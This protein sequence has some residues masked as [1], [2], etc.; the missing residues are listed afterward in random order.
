MH[1]CMP[2][3]WRSTSLTIACLSSRIIGRESGEQKGAAAS[4]LELVKQS[5]PPARVSIQPQ[6]PQTSSSTDFL[7]MGS[8]RK[9]FKSISDKEKDE[10]ADMAQLHS[11]LKQYDKWQVEHIAKFLREEGDKDDDQSDYYTSIL[12][13]SSKLSPSTFIFKSFLPYSHLTL[14]FSLTQCA[15]RTM[16]VH[17]SVT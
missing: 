12:I 13:T 11:K 14:Y 17:V 7:S 1:C 6:T 2:S 10:A 8:L 5:L 9:L 15:N 3:I 4:G 16:L